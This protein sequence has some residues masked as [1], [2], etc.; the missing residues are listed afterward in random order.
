[1]GAIV[2]ETGGILVDHGWLRILGSEHERLRRTL[3][4]WNEGR[5]NG[6]Y[7]V[8]DDAIGGFFAINGGALGPDVKNVCY[9]APDSL[10]W[11]SLEMGYSEF[12]QWA[13]TEKLDV[14]YEWIRWAGWESDA[15]RLHGDRCYCFYPPLFTREGAGGNGRRGEVPVEESWGVQM[16]FR[17]QLGLSG[18]E[19]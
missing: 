9:F 16:D 13:C 7:L 4:G 19:G 6:F 8:A 10:E 12:L 18:N 3:P 17:A 14:F 11:E 5:S 1:M 15:S 2:Y